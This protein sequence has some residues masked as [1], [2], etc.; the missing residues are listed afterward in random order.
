[1]VENNQDLCNELSVP[2][3]NSK[4]NIIQNNHHYYFPTINTNYNFNRFINSDCLYF[5]FS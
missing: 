1:M 5:I 4:K 2:M 3:R